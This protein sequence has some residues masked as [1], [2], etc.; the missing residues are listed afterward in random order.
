MND[1]AAILK[2]LR[3]ALEQ[4]R[5]IDLH[6]H[7]IGLGFLDGKLL[8]S[9]EVDTVSAKK[10]ALEYAAAL[11]G[12]TELVDQLLVKPA[13]V[14]EDGSLCDLVFEALYADSA[15]NDVELKLRAGGKDKPGRSTPRTATGT[16]EIEVEAGIVTLSGEVESYAHKSLAGVLA[17]WRR[18]T[19]DVRNHLSVAHPMDDPDG[20]MSDVLRMV[21]EKDRFVDAAQ[22]RPRCHEFIAT[23]EGLVRNETERNLAET[24]AWC[25]FGVVDV[26]NR[27]EVV[28]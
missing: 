1:T 14:L 26:Q 9:G 6:H 15:F 16:I 8:I 4:E 11:A 2:E 12:G 22:I 17:W 23:L 5:H 13:E 18:G 10:L 20:E 28:A 3:A 25:L 27:L 21:L 19:R 7:P 24:D